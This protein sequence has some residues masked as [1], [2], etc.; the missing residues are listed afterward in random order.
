MKAH[1]AGEDTDQ[2]AGELV[3]I[4]EYNG[5]GS[6]RVHVSRKEKQYA[7]E[8]STEKESAEVEHTPRMRVKGTGAGLKLANCL[9]LGNSL[10]ATNRNAFHW[11]KR[12][13]VTRGSP[14]ERIHETWLITGIRSAKRR[15]FAPCFSSVPPGVLPAGRTR[16]TLRNTPSIW[17]L[18]KLPFLLTSIAMES[19]TWSLGSIGTRRRG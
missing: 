8:D 6:I 5:I 10:T 11:M 3:S 12:Y 13:A 2:L 9:R 18:Q 14:W 1:R 4:D 17:E 7:A 15:R 16:S 19:S